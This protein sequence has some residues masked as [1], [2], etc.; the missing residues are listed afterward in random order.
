MTGKTLFDTARE[1]LSEAT[2]KK[3]DNPVLT[4]INAIKE[5]IKKL[6]KLRSTIKNP[7]DRRQADRTLS[8]LGK[9]L[10]EVIKAFKGYG[11]DISPMKKDNKDPENRYG[12]SGRS[13]PSQYE[14]GYNPKTKRNSD[15]ENRYG[16]SGRS[17]PSQYEPGYNPKTKR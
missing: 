3:I 2:S 4:E 1:I 12:G 5:S 17:E 6:N 8:A 9:E 14:P 7:S 16:G 11:M 10:N 15:P 13:E